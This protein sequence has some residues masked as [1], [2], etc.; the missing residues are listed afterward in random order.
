MIDTRG[1]EI[2]GVELG[3]LETDPAPLDLEG[4]ENAARYADVLVVPSDHSIQARVL[5]FGQGTG[6]GL[7][8]G[9]KAG[10][11]CIVLYPGN[12]ENSAI[13]VTGLG[14]NKS[15][16]PSSA[17]GLKA[18]LLHDGGIELRDADGATVRRVVHDELLSQLATYLTALEAFMTATALDII[19][20][21]ATAA[22]ATAF[23]GSVGGPI[24]T[25]KVSLDLVDQFASANVKVSE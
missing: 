4:Y 3:V 10:D 15:P 8:M 17:D 2:A 20:S 13:A 6:R 11:E 18:V 7:F 24:S 14:N 22:A 5:Q 19:D 9:P 25:F 12:R 21:P 1:Y 16:H 23:Q